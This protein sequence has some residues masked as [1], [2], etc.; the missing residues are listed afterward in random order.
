MDKIEIRDLQNVAKNMIV[1][2]KQHSLFKPVLDNNPPMVAENKSQLF[3]I[4]YIN[5]DASNHQTITLTI[6]SII[7]RVAQSLN[8]CNVINQEPSGHNNHLYG[9]LKLCPKQFTK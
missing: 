5:A 7:D 2:S 3:D 4:Q 9:D 1:G 6:R 8:I